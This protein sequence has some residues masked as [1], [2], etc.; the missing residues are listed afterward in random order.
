[1]CKGHKIVQGSIRDEVDG[2]HCLLLRRLLLHIH[3]HHP[4]A[5]ERTF[6]GFLVVDQDA[7]SV[8]LIGDGPELAELAPVAK[9]VATR[10][11]LDG[12]YRDAAQVFKYDPAPVS[13]IT[14]RALVANP[15]ASRN[16]S[17]PIAMI[18]MAQFLM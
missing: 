6:C 14:A 11:A 9:P 1:M 4:E 7:S 10:M 17:G 8:Q 16:F 5:A 13:L 12:R 15:N 2:D 3:F 18:I